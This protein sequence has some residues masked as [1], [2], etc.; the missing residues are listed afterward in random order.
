[1]IA[2]HTREPDQERRR[3][4]DTTNEARLDEG[5]VPTGAHKNREPQTDHQTRISAEKTICSYRGITGNASQP[6]AGEQ[7]ETKTRR[8]ID[9]PTALDRWL[10][11]PNRRDSK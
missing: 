6:D 3:Q 5:V 10:P 2:R 1:M 11:A 8:K 9:P 4:R 7:T